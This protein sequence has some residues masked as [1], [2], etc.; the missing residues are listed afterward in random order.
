MS[1]AVREQALGQGLCGRD[2]ITTVDG[3]VDAKA[4]FI[5]QGP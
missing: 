2:L 1:L 5:C 4:G 3:R